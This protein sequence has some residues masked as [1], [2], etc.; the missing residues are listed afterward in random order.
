MDGSSSDHL[1]NSDSSSSMVVF[2]CVE[3]EVGS[4]SACLSEKAEASW[5]GTE[6][7]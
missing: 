1:W 3:N 4:E 5:K 2:S 6:G 7:R